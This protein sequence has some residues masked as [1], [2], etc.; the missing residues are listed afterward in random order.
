MVCLGSLSESF[1]TPAW[2]ASTTLMAPQEQWGRVSGLA[3]AS[4]STS[5]IVGPLLAGYLMEVVALETILFIDL[6]SFVFALFTLLTS[7]IPSPQKTTANTEKT[8]MLQEFRQGWH[9]V[10][11]CPGLPALLYFFTAIN[12][13]ASV[14][15]ILLTPMVL[16]FSTPARLGIILSGVG[17]GMLAGSL[18]QATWGGPKRYILGVMIPSAV[19]GL[20]F[21]FQGIRPLWWLVMISGG[22]G[23]ACLPLINGSSQVIWQKMVPP[24]LQGRVFSL[25]RMVAWS[26][27]PIAFVLAGILTE[28]L[29]SPAMVEGGTLARIM[30]PMIGVGPSR[31]AGLLFVIQGILLMGIVLLAWQHKPLRMLGQA[32]EPEPH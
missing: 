28:H 26:A 24:E 23:A 14:R 16:D 19:L 32:A 2:M 1:Q 5:V 3:Q 9:F 22:L 30:G 27:N 15:G 21:V 12:F 7:R 10:K 18:L 11:A 25:R 8:S 29:F 4:M 13:A 6:A 31:G 17:V 20:S